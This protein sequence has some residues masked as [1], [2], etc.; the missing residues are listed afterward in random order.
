MK[1]A[2][3]NFRPPI[4]TPL[5]MRRV[6]PSLAL[7][8]AAFAGP[9]LANEQLV[10]RSGQIAGAPGAYGQLD[11]TITCTYVAG[12]NLPL[13]PY[14]FDS[15][16]FAAASAGPSAR[17]IAIVCPV[18]CMESSWRPIGLRSI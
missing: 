10:L 1:L 17:P 14:R 9:A 15:T 18:I 8:A 11:D 13:A 2:R 4:R 6:V 5:S 16:H 3:P 7:A 12:C